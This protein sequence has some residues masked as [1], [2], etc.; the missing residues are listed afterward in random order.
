MHE[1]SCPWSARLESPPL[2]FAGRSNVD[3]TPARP[4]PAIVAGYAAL[5]ETGGPGGRRLTISDLLRIPLVQR[6]RLAGSTDRYR[7]LGLTPDYRSGP[8]FRLA[9]WNG[10]PKLSSR[11]YVSTA[12]ARAM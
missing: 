2:F 6:P 12:S 11:A 5:A 9:E 10:N 1:I 4:D 8:P 3:S 7:Y